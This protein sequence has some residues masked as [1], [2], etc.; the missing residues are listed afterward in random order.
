MDRVLTINELN[1]LMPLVTLCAD[2]QV[3]MPQFF[4][5]INEDGKVLEDDRVLKYF[6]PFTDTE[7]VTQFSGDYGVI[8]KIDCSEPTLL[9]SFTGF[10][11]QNLY[12]KSLQDLET[13][14]IPE[15]QKL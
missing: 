9:D 11:K 13:I 1:I 10:M 3:S 5:S 2:N 6:T 12:N 14:G 4:Q 8:R 7:L 15:S